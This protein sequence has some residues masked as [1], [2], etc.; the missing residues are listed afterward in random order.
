MA[1]KLRHPKKPAAEKNT[2]TGV[3]VRLGS[4]N[5]LSEP[6]RF[7]TEGPARN[8]IVNHFE[9]WKPWCARS[10]SKMLPNLSNA[11]NQVPGLTIGLK[12]QR[13]EALMDDYSDPP[14]ILVAEVWR[15]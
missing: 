11:I 3:F 10:N 2:S 9:T 15:Q 14:M 1:K 8:A 7:E 5:T 6:K 12:P 13:L 4:G